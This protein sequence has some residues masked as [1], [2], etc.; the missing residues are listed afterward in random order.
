VA[1]QELLT[2]EDISDRLRQWLLAALLRLASQGRID[3]A[4]IELWRADAETVRA[5]KVTAFLQDVQSLIALGS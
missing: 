5:S 3:E 4:P 1:I 2:D